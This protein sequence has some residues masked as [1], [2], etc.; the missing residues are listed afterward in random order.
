MHVSFPETLSL[1]PHRGYRG[2]MSRNMNVSSHQLTL[3]NPRLAGFTQNLHAPSRT[4]CGNVRRGGASRLSPQ[5]TDYTQ[6]D[7]TRVGTRSHRE[8]LGDALHRGIHRAR[9][10]FTGEPAASSLRCVHMLLTSHPQAT[11]PSRDCM[12]ANTSQPQA[13]TWRPSLRGRQ[14]P[15]APQPLTFPIFHAYTH[16]ATIRPCAA[17]ARDPAL[18]IALAHWRSS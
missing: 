11:W 16:G 7:G 17:P 3:R 9:C 5:L 4:A 18:Q 6:R 12:H 14:L 8:R 10:V 15:P 13:A 2:S 1:Q